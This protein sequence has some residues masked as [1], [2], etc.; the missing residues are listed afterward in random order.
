MS[1]EFERTKLLL[2]DWRKG[3][4]NARD[5][6]FD[7]LYH[8]LRKVSAALLRAESNNSLSTGDLVNEAASIITLMIRMRS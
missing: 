4:M 6:L 3:D 2:G 5:Q 8:E 1:V 7:R